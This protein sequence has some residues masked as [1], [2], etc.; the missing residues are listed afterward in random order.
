MK[1][2]LVY[3]CAIASSMLWIGIVAPLIVRIFGVPH[4]LGFWRID[5]R[6]QHLRAD[7]YF[8]CVGVLSFG[9]GL[10]LLMT[11]LDFLEAKVLGE[12][13]TN[14]SYTLVHIG[15]GVVAGVIFGSTSGPRGDKEARSPQ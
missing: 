1:V 3:L 10:S 9:G 13:A 5:R 8:W 11:L 12:K 14:P 2:V 6:N 4:K 7:Q 15:I